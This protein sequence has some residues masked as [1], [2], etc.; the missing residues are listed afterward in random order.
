MQGEIFTDFLPEEF[1]TKRFPLVKLPRICRVRILQIIEKYSGFL[2]LW[3][4]KRVCKKLNLSEVPVVFP[5]VFR[6][7]ILDQIKE[8]HRANYNKCLDKAKIRLFSQTVFDKAMVILK[9]KVPFSLFKSYDEPY[10]REWPWAFILKVSMS[11]NHGQRIWYEKAVPCLS[12][13][14]SDCNE[15]I[16]QVFMLRINLNSK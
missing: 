13:C 14:L 1:D 3:E 2:P 12:D 6:K 15:E 4:V 8:E 11:I 7:T 5:N 16:E 9:W 10:Y